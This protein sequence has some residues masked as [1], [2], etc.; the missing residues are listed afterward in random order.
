LLLQ[1]RRATVGS[2]RLSVPKE[3]PSPNADQYLFTCQL[4]EVTTEN[5]LQ[6]RI[7][8]RLDFFFFLVGWGGLRQG[9]TM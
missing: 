3:F 4:D 7:L 5:E 2:L 9:I 1:K 6:G 8:H